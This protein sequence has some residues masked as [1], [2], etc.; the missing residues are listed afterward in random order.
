MN[1]TH[2]AAFEADSNASI[3]GTHWPNE[4]DLTPAQQ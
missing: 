1:I 2:T 4:E 3:D